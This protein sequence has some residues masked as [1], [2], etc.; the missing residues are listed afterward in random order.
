MSLGYVGRIHEG[1]GEGEKALEYYIRFMEIME[2]LVKKEPG[3]TDWQRELGVSL[4]YVGRIHEGLGEGEKALGRY[5]RRTL[6]I[7]KLLVEKEPRV[8]DRHIG[9]ASAL[10]DMF[11]VTEDEDKKREFI[12][13][14]QSITKSLVDD[15][16][17][18]ILKLNVLRSIFSL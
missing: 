12:Q 5:Y 7:R 17:A 2:S 10:L 14:A 1:L 16:V 3:R 18:A 8:I 6:E 4:G 13:E 9:L 15:G 11:R